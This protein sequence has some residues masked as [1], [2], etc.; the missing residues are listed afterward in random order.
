MSDLKE[1]LH[2]CIDEDF[3]VKL[4]ADMIKIESYA[5]VKNQE[6][7]VAL[8]LKEVLEQYDIPCCI[9]EVADGR[10]N[11]IAEIDSGKPGKTLMLNGHMDTVK[12]DGMEGAFEPRIIDGKLYGR[13]AS[14]MKGPVA[15]MAGAMIALKQTGALEAGK[16]ILAAVIDEEHKSLGTIDLLES[17]VT[18]DGAIVGEPTQLQVCTA[19]RGLEWF[20]FH[21]IG[22]AVHGGAQR[23]GINAIQKAVSFINALE[24]DLIPEVYS[25][26]HPLLQEATLN[27]GVIHGG[28]QLSTVAGECDLYVDRRYLPYETYD[29]VTAQF[30]NLLDKLAAEDPKFRCEM[31]VMDESVM[32][33]GYVHEPMYT[34]LDDPLVLQI[35]ESVT[36]VLETEP[37][38]SFFP[39]WTDGGLLRSYGNIPT[40]V[41]GPGLIECCHAL[42]EYIPVEHLKKAAMIYALT[43]VDFCKEK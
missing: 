21:F 29:E 14:D 38:M 25:R 31:K 11:L 39:A 18:A 16:V 24:S 37:V 28:T 33:E 27:Y 26:K 41:L 12:A 40:V 35:R 6:T 17:G 19:H 36:E 15:S 3:L 10:C 42:N 34:E 2:S 8:Y 23:E 9:K 43:A 32:K 22:K 5:G 13:G 7:G 1:K 30:R 4:T 20:Q